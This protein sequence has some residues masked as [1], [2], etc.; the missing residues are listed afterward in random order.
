MKQT[1]GAALV[2][3][4]GRD[5]YQVIDKNPVFRKMQMTMGYQQTSLFL[6]MEVKRGCLEGLKYKVIVF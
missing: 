1:S 3:S 5:E 6:N 4:W 2:N